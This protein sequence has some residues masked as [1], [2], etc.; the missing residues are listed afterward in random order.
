MAVVT[1]EQLEGLVERL[2]SAEPEVRGHDAEAA[3]ALAGGAADLE[4]RIGADDLDGA[5]DS[6]VE[7]WKAILEYPVIRRVF[8][9]KAPRDDAGSEDAGLVQTADAVEYFQNEVIKGIGRLPR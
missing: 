8:A 2:R 3:D 1:K 9:T 5:Q 6:A 7:L 4:Q